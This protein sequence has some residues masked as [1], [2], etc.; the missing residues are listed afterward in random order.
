LTELEYHRINNLKDL[1][2]HYGISY[3]APSDAKRTGLHP[4]SIDVVVSTNTLEHIPKEDI[5]GILCEMKRILKP[6]G[7]ISSKIDYSDH[8]AAT[9]RNIDR[10]NYLKF[11]DAE[12]DKYNHSNH[13]QNRLRHHD[14]RKIFE[15]AG[16][17]TI[18][19]RILGQCGMPNFTLNEKFDGGNPETLAISGYFLVQN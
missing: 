5:V 11:S 4:E 16:F 9:D 3:N 1:V 10:L 12:W 15:E 2:D 6:G 13:Y 17:K 14:Y 19:N 7:F 8:Y 18:K